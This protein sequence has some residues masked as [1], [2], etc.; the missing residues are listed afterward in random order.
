MTLIIMA[1][2]IGS[3]FGNGKI[4]Q[5]EPVTDHGNLLMDFSLYDAFRAGFDKVVFVIRKDIEALFIERVLDRIP[6]EYDV[7]YVFQEKDDI[8]VKKELAALRSKPWGTG[9]AVLAAK[10]S[11]NGN[12]AV[13]N[14]DDFYGA[15]AFKKMAECLKSMDNSGNPEPEYAMCGFRIGNTLSDNGTVTRGVCT[16][17]DGNL[18]R[19]EETKNISRDEGGIIR[20]TY[21]GEERVIPDDAAVSMNMWGFTPDYMDR[22]ESG[23]ADFLSRRDA[24]TVNDGEF[25]VPIHVGE[26]VGAGAC[27][28]KV[29]H[30]DSKW[31]GMTYAADLDEVRREIAALTE[32]GVYPKYLFTRKRRRN[33]TDKMIEELITDSNF[34]YLQPYLYN[35]PYA[36]RCELGQGE[37]DGT[38]FLRTSKERADIIYGM[39]FPNGADAVIFNHYIRDLCEDGDAHEY[40][41]PQDIIREV[42]LNTELLLEF[43]GKY[44]HR[45][46]RDLPKYEDELPPEDKYP[47]TRHRIVCYSDGKGFDAERIIGIM[48][49]ERCSTDSPEISFVSFPHDCILSIY[50]ARGCDVVFASY[51]KMAAFYPKLEPYFLDYD[52]ELMKN[53]FERK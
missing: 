41:R 29:L 17:S 31:F 39:L 38:D 49:G 34:S 2:G 11:I 52:R 1:A 42:T 30:T 50:D 53:R 7:S 36:L 5:L 19:L 47:A 9:H 32:Q 43:Q 44:R 37:E 45:V 16:V 51:E 40:F 46:V 24:S 33:K 4:K 15:D 21:N 12:F 25:L 35:N 14:A 28:V 20:G 3:R 23:F 10:D 6:K 13:I 18:V 8:P 48:L 27:S 22:L 26:L